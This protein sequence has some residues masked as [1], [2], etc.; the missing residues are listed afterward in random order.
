M[1]L[2]AIEK[3]S[4]TPAKYQNTPI[5]R[6]LEFHNLGLPFLKYGRAELLLGM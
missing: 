1:S 4:D 3:S 2:L 5:G 6:L